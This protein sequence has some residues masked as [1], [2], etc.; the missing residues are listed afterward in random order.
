MNASAA[1]A[2]TPLRHI[3]RWLR[4]VGWAGSPLATST[5]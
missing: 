4:T 5:Y 1:T 3:G 2:D